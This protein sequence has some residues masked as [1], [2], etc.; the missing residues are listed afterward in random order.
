VFTSNLHLSKLVPS[1]TELSH[2]RD[3]WY[4]YATEHYGIYDIA[5]VWVHAVA[6]VEMRLP[7]EISEHNLL[8]LKMMSFMLGSTNIYMDHVASTCWVTFTDF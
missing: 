2:S 7:Q 3:Q 1:L 4:L 5:E 8:S 6:L